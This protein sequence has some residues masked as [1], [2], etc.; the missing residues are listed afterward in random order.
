MIEMKKLFDS[1]MFVDEHGFTTTGMVIALL[2][3]L[4]LV[5]SA[6]QVYRISSTAAHIQDVADASALTAENQVAEFMLIAR[7]CDAVVLSMS[8]A[9]IVTTGLGVA[10]LCTPVTARFSEQLIDAGSKILDARNAFSARAKKVLM[11]LQEVLPFLA[12]ANA[13]GVAVANDSTVQGADYI[14]AAVLVPWEGAEIEIDDEEKS[15]EAIDKVRE[16]AD[17]VRQKAEEAE[18]ATKESQ[19]AKEIAYQHDCGNAPGYCM[20]ERASTLA[21]I[22]GALNP[23]YASVDAWSFAVALDRARVYY[24]ARLEQEAPLD[25]TVEEAARSSLRAR[26]Y[27]Y[28]VDQ[29][30][31]AYVVET[32]DSFDYRLPRLP[33]S[34]PEVR[35][36]PLYT[37]QRYPVTSDGE[38]ETMHAW[39]GC[40]LAAGWV[41][42][43]SVQELEAGEFQTCPACTFEPDS[44]GNVAAASTSIEN[45]FEH[46]YKVVV[47]QA[48]AYKQAID[49]A[50]PAK[51]EVKSR[52]TDL[53]ERLKEAAQDAAGKRIRLEPPGRYGV[54]AM[55]ANV[56]PIDPSGRFANSFALQSGSLGPC[57]AVSAATLLDEGNDEGASAI[58]SLLDGLKDEGGA[59]IGALGIALD[60]WSALL[61]AYANGQDAL[62]DA[63]E[64]GLNSLPLAGSSG[65]GTWAANK[66]RDL[67]EAVGL[68]PADIGALKPV[69]VNS[70]HVAQKAEGGFASGYLQVKRQIVA[71]PASSGDLFSWVVD[72]G[73][74][75][76]LSRIASWDAQ[77]EVLEI[78][79]LG[80]DG[81]K[82]PLSIPLPEAVRHLGIDAIHEAFSRLRGVHSSA[83]TMNE[84]R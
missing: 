48:A 52:V 7:T 19:L 72:M 54:V 14:A 18:E 82:V 63:L 30:A 49:K 66:L 9:G 50:A 15:R 32:P 69:L 80:P 1:R 11:S 6:A 77:I 8:L 42:C 56:G 71:N 40:P 21:G 3:S 34:L 61:G 4:S 28:Q 64:G 39:E 60:C 13:A 22:D 62:T 33:K 83:T 45:G 27:R 53:L 47:D 24:R 5:F 78:E 20:Y 10:A 12:A 17:E 37:E 76:A 75:E 46:H 73:E 44:L 38:G 55:A 70:G 79:L 16:E 25:G 51:E 35:N 74:A 23:H 68:Q 2:V 43:G 81:P 84:W 29:L 58:S 26:F 36:T 57:V 67:I 41:R 65:L 31:T 59:A